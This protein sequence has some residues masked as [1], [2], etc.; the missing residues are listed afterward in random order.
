SRSVS[1][2]GIPIR[3]PS[4]LP[5]PP[6]RRSRWR[7]SHFFK[8]PDG[9]RRLTPHPRFIAARAVKKTQACIGEAEE[10]LGDRAGFRLGCPAYGHGRRLASGL[11]VSSVRAKGSSAAIGLS[12]SLQRPQ[13]ARSAPGG[14]PARGQK[15][16]LDL[17][18]ASFDRASTT[19]SPQQACQ[20]M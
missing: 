14:L 16:A 11:I 9:L 19:K 18:Q 4:R 5:K 12:E 15:F 7:P 6:S 20:S 2:L 8:G 10:T 17:K 3:N 13:V 1:A